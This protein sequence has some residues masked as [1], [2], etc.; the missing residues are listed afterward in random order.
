MARTGYQKPAIQR[1]CLTPE[2]AV[3][4]GCKLG[5]GNIYDS[6][7]YGGKACWVS[8]V[9]YQGN[10]VYILCHQQGT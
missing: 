8:Q 6:F 9:P 5:S 3:L 1:V 10:Y 2:E 7:T 4:N